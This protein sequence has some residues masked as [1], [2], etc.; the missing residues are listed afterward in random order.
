MSASSRNLDSAVT[1]LRFENVRLRDDDDVGGGDF[2]PLLDARDDRVLDRVPEDDG[3][4]D[5]LV[6]V[7]EREVL[8]VDGD[9]TVLASLGVC[10]RRGG[11]VLGPVPLP[12]PPPPPV[13]LEAVL[14]RLR[15]LLLRLPAGPKHSSPLSPASTHTQNLS[16]IHI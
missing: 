6:L 16:L 7:L 5:E 3:D 10:E 4:D 14:V 12:P 9:D 13:T 11:G 15:L 1:T 8:A 2:V